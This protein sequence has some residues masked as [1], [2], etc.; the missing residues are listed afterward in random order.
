M[1]VCLSVYVC[2]DV[3]LSLSVVMS[4]CMSGLQRDLCSQRGL[5]TGS[6][7]QTFRVALPR[8][9]RSHYDRIIMPVLMMQ[10]EL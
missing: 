6:D 4:L 3:C 7:I 1:S 5:E 8:K 9:L 10:V 2:S